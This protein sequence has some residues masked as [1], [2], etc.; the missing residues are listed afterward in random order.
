MVKGHLEVVYTISATVLT[1][2][3]VNIPAYSFFHSPTSPP[4]EKPNIQPPAVSF[5]SFVCHL[6]LY[7]T[8]LYPYFSGQHSWPAEVLRTLKTERDERVL[9]EVIDADTKALDLYPLLTP[10][11]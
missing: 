3:D 9:I 2:G 8:T 11:L 6:I 1:L 10:E 7:I 4:I 5:V